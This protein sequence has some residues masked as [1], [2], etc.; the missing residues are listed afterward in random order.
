MTNC[1]RS[2]KGTMAIEGIAPSKQGENIT[3][4]YLNGRIDS[5]TAI[6]QIIKFHLGGGDLCQEQKC[7]KRTKL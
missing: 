2:V 5:N 4:L 6:E 7:K 3:D 1:K